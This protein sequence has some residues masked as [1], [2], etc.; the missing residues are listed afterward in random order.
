MPYKKPESV[1]NKDKTEKVEGGGI[2]D[3]RFDIPRMVNPDNP[4]KN[5]E[6][7]LSKE[8]EHRGRNMMA[9]MEVEYMPDDTN[10][11][12]RLSLALSD[13]ESGANVAKLK[14]LL[15][16]DPYSSD[17]IAERFR[18]V[19]FWRIYYRRVAKEFR[20]QGIAREA[21]KA[22]HQA[23]LD[24]ERSND[25]AFS[26]YSKLTTGLSGV[27]RMVVDKDWLRGELAARGQEMPAG[28]ED[29]EGPG[30]GYIPT[31]HSLEKA[32]NLIARRDVVM[33]IDDRS[34]DNHNLQDIN[35]VRAHGGANP[36]LEVIFKNDDKK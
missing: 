13:K 36:I 29:A 34:N 30:F 35:F 10:P 17:Q 22:M 2:G 28:L 9:N 25:G 6:V 16:A 32:L 5:T 3:L 26:F 19:P 21:F 7:E 18:N 15:C 14:A 24:L 11:G 33:D 20:Q 12:Y 4:R 31:P 23:F 27:A 8:V 1:E